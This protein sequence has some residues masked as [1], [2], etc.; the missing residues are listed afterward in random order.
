MP[1]MAQPMMAPAAA[2]VPVSP[3][4]PRKPCRPK[5]THSA[6][7]ASAIATTIDRPNIHGS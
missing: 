3:S 2:T 7:V 5:R 4:L 6:R 1:E